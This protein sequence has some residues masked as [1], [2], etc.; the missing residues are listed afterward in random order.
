MNKKTIITGMVMALLMLTACSQQLNLVAYEEVTF[1]DREDTFGCGRYM[2]SS[3]LNS[4][5]AV[6]SS[7][8]EYEALLNQYQTLHKCEWGKEPQV[9]DFSTKTLLGQYAMGGGCSIDYERNVKRFD[10]DK[11]IIYTVE[12]K[13]KGNCDM[14]GFSMNWI[15]VSKN[16]I[17]SG[18]GIEFKVEK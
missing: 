18:Y 17:P 2:D 11:K 13:E 9:I 10:E 16:L 14:A 12:V 3:V 7:Q 5:T 6:I 1:F 8:E 4:G 15:T